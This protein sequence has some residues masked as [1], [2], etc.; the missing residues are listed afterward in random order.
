[1]KPYKVHWPFQF[2]L[3]LFAFVEL[4]VGEE[5]ELSVT[6]G[7]VASLSCIISQ[8]LPY[9]RPVGWYWS[10]MYPECSGSDGGKILD[11]Y[12]DGRTVFD[13]AF[14][15]RVLV[16]RSKIKKGDYSITI[17]GV[18]IP[19]SGEF[20]CAHEDFPEEKKVRLIVKQGCW[21]NLHLSVDPPIVSV[22]D[23]VTLTCTYCGTKMVTPRIKWQHDGLAISDTGVVSIIN[24]GQSLV[25]SRVDQ[26][27][28]KKYGCSMAKKD[29]IVTEICL[30][31]ELDFLDVTYAGD[32]DYP[33]STPIPELTTTATTQ[34][35]TTTVA[36][37]PETTNAS[38]NVWNG[39][40][41]MQD[42]SSVTSRQP[43]SFPT[44]VTDPVKPMETS[45]PWNEDVIPGQLGAT[46]KLCPVVVGNDRRGDFPTYLCIILAGILLLIL[47]A[48]LTKRYRRFCKFGTHDVEHNASN[49]NNADTPSSDVPETQ[50]AIL[51]QSENGDGAKE[52][53]DGEMQE[54]NK[55]DNEDE[56]TSEKEIK[57][58]DV[59]DP[60]QAKKSEIEKSEEEEQQ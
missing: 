53:A 34:E 1:M 36:P 2:S 4:A 29:S 51:M 40:E 47:I 13:E 59:E 43:E 38:L 35:S 37:K 33:V 55:N 9:D 26:E 60:N 28:L 20:I 48:F 15:G 44:T 10:P 22:G 58:V 45:D 50:D 52:S 27:H 19:D 54:P 25:I 21:S 3:A 46:E 11:I 8:Q 57:E 6:I 12:P 18:M 24:S 42:T 41:W 17:R 14:K 32:Y 7:N 5:Q 49:P 39:V 23:K 56:H 30:N 31:I 16:H